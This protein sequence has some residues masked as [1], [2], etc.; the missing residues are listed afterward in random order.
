MFENQFKT[1]ASMDEIKTL[2]RKL[3][4][5]NHPDFG[6]L[7]ENMQALNA[8]FAQ[9]CADFAR[10]DARQR[11]TTAHAA[12]KKSAADFHDMDNLAEE[13]RQTIESVLN[14]IPADVDLELC[15]LWLWATGNTKPVKDILKAN[16]FKWANEK[17]AWFKAFVP[18]FNRQRRS[19][20]EIRNMHG[21]TKFAHAR[22]DDDERQRVKSFEFAQGI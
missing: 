17:K 14:A 7:L 3:A 1:C 15:G 4:R 21:S 22:Q 11:Q 18:S 16:G 5:A 8:D 12:G 9:A 13:I 2:Y 6:G 20:D 19:L 10:R